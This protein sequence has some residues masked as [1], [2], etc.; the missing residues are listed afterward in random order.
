MGE[1]KAIVL[2]PGAGERVAGLAYKATGGDG[3][4]H[5]SFIEETL[6]PEA[7]GPPL[8][9]H[10]SHDETFYVVR[11][12]LTMLAG[13][14]TVVAAAGAFVF[15]PAGTVHGFANRSGAPVTFVF[16]HAPGGYEELFRELEP[17][18]RPDGT[19]DRQAGIALATKYQDRIVGP[20]L[21]A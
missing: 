17:L 18:R 9:I 20:P 5:F 19:I 10:D 7:P 12:D 14:Q 11:G 4:G 21:G 15:V 3:F 13:E 16:L 6:A 8:H 1:S 2:G